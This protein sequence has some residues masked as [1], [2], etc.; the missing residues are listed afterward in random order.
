MNLEHTRRISLINFL[1]NV[2]I[3]FTTHSDHEGKSKNFVF[4]FSYKIGT[5][6]RKDLNTKSIT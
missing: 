1:V 2:I 4:C 3:A 6:L 5:L